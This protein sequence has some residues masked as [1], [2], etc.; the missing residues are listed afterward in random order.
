MEGSGY[1]KL[2]PI[3]TKKKAVINMMNKECEK[4]CGECNQCK[5]SKMC[6]KW[7]VTRVLN[8][9]DDNPQRIT[10]ELREQAEKYKWDGITFPTKVK[11]IHIFFREKNNN[12][13]INVFGYDDEAKKIY[14]IRI[15]ELKD[16]LKTINLF[17]HDDNHYCV[18]KD[19]SK[20]VSSQLSKKDHGKDICLR[21]LNAFGRLTKEEKKLKKKSLLEIHEELCSDQKLQHS[22]YPKPGGTAKFKNYERLHDVPFAVYAD[23]ESFIEP[24]QYAEQDPSKSFTNKY[25]NH[26]PSGFC[27]VIKCMDESV[28]STKTVLKTASYGGEDMGK[29]FVDSLTEDLKPVYEILKNSRP[30]MMSD[31]EKSK[32]EKTKE[33]YACKDV[34]GTMRTNEKTKKKEKVTKC[35]DHCHITG[36]YR[37]A[38]CDKCNLRMRVPKFVPVLFHN[39]E[40]YDS[41]LFVKS[42]GLTD[43]DIKCIPKTDEKYISFGKNIP[44]DDGK[45]KTAYLEM[46]F[47]AFNCETM[48]DYHD[49]YLKTDMLLLADIMTEFR[50]VCKEV[51]ELDALHYYTV[52]G[53]AWD[54]MLKITEV[55]IDLISDPD[56]YLMVEKGIR[57]GISTITKRYAKANNKY[58]KDYDKD[59]MSVYIPYLDTN[60]LYGWAMRH[61]LPVKDFRWMSEDELE[62]W[63]SKPCIFEV[64]LEYPKEL[65]DFHSEYPL[66]PEQLQIDKVRN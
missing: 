11:D 38:A 50:R 40:G 28:Y 17:L 54:A 7:A 24:V 35:R 18:V 48:K 56:M 27:Y 43:G 39:L 6:F 8:P 10:K 32:H 4:K 59:Q 37:G 61:K 57:G 30:M 23:F 53:L 55:E 22:I 16:P 62:N 64:D 65:H 1:S 12:I 44:M 52:P 66:A 3:I 51:Y 26:I 46:R 58:I 25:Q 42:L 63:E 31:S 49:L 21:C 36:K 60:N 47:L 15:A 41:H 34:F 29:A 19:L 14:T 9:V 33:C 13:N 5:E 45:E 20:L 2:P